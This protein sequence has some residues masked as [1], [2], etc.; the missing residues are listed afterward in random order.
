MKPTRYRLIIPT[1]G[2]KDGGDIIAEIHFTKHEDGQ[3]YY[4][5]A[6]VP[7]AVP[8]SLFDTYTGQLNAVN[9]TMKRRVREHYWLVTGNRKHT[10]D[11]VVAEFECAPNERNRM[12]TDHIILPGVET[13]EE[14]GTLTA[15]HF[16]GAT[17]R[18]HERLQET[19]PE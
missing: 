17:Y 3:I 2:E 18:K 16:I 11:E 14:L 4:D 1:E 9:P 13:P 19:D 12:Q 10:G 6:V 7:D 8:S 15:L 5:S